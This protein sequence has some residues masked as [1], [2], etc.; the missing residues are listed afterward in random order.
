[1]WLHLSPIVVSTRWRN[2]SHLAR[3]SAG[4]RRARV[5]GGAHV[6]KS[7]FDLENP[8]VQVTLQR[9]P[10]YYTQ[11]NNAVAAG[12]PPAM[13]IM[14]IDQLALF[15]ANGVVQPV[16]DLVDQLGLSEADFSEAVWAGTNW[17][18][19]QY[20]IPLDVHPAT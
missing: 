2:G 18:G 13:M 10:E 5:E 17:Q 19:E 4:G 8:N 15:A 3:G 7:Q 1:M 11:I 16:G 12:P 9:L 6:D 14:H 20:S